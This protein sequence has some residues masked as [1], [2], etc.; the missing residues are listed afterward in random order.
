M[1]DYLRKQNRQAISGVV[2]VV[3]STNPEEPAQYKGKFKLASWTHKS[4]EKS[5]IAR[6]EKALN[7]A[8]TLPN[9]DH[10]TGE[11]SVMSNVDYQIWQP[12]KTLN[13]AFA[14]SSG[15]LDPFDSLSIRLGPLSERLLV[16]Y[17]TEYTMNSVAINA[18]GDFFHHVKKDPA[19][20]HSILYLVALHS[21][22][23]YGLVDS[24]ACLYHGSQAFRLINE[25]LRDCSGTFSDVTIAA[26]A[27]LVNKENLN[28]R[29][30]LSEM[31]KQGLEK[32]VRVR[33]GVHHLQGVFRR[34]VTWSDFCYANVWSCQPAFPRLLPRPSTD[35]SLDINSTLLNPTHLFGTS[36]PIVPIFHALRSL[37]DS[38][39]SPKAA[40][41]NRMKASNAIYGLEYDL[42]SLN[43][44]L[45]TSPELLTCILS[46]E[47]VP[48]KTAA[49]IYLW[50][51]IRELPPT[52][53]LVYRL[54]QRLQ[55]S[56]VGIL[57]GW[58]SSSK[59][60]QVWLLWI[61]F[62]GGIAAVGRGESGWFVGEM[63]GVCRIL[64]IWDKTALRGCLEGVLW[65]EEFFGEKL[66]LMWQDMVLSW[67]AESHWITE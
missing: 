43:K 36:S 31:H 1:R 57:P 64:G 16:H 24:P 2:E 50:L 59:E 18:E 55:G 29:Y 4:K 54:V 14:L 30:E 10:R 20:F 61:M 66:S 25:R 32:M 63:V 46:F 15:S 65:Q 40:S 42:L 9:E 21:D 48:L 8:V 39:S 7:A 22:L 27:M 47:S 41:L 58:W 6:R 62:V 52:S 51:V 17:N 23:K 19:L 3:E 35:T 26:V 5:V 11:D 60:R 45:P 53:E 37:S 56:L 33:G 12:R 44:P 28:G 34:I 38:L 49:H 67:D 13:P